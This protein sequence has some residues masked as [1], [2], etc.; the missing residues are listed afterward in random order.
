MSDLRSRR[1]LDWLNFFSANV[2]TGFG[3]FIAVYLTVQEWTEA[4]IGLALSIGTIAAM[5][6]QVPAG[7]LVDQLRNK[8]KAALAAVL[9]I[10]GSAL[11]FAFFPER[12]P[13]A[14][15]EVLHGFAS[16]V[17]TPAIAAISLALVGRAALGERLGRNARFA[18]IGNGLAAAVMGA[19]GSYV[20]ERAVFLLTA[21][22]VVPAL[23]ALGAIRPADLTHRPHE[24][25]VTHNDWAGIRRLLL[26]RGVL[27]FSLCAAL[28]TLANAAMLPLAGNEITVQAGS[29]ANII[30]AACIV[31]PQAV[32]ALISPAV[33]HLADRWGRRIV[34]VLGFSALPVRG[35]LLAVMGNPYELIAIQALDGVSGAALGVLLP[36]VASDL[37]RGTNRFNLC[38]GLIG[39]MVGVGATL[40]TALAGWIAEAFGHEAAF[41]GLGAAGLLA[42]LLVLVAMPETRPDAAA[43]APAQ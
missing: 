9:A 20:S 4:D 15:A 31:V 28:F 11:I 7:A 1:G 41:L 10:M 13:V 37:T 33:G 23:F 21:A 8:R 27:V 19:C 22:L 25:E 43:A 2:Q 30:I 39:L 6:S 42:V 36:L 35:V 14:I 12:A 32:V 3:P 26:S 18:S 40:S 16:C 29:G 5:V 17:L 34:L 38:M 24:E